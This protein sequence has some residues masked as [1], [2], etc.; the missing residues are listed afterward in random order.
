M[1]CAVQNNENL[2]NQLNR[3]NISS[4]RRQI[5]MKQSNEPF[6]GTVTNAQSEITDMDNFPYNR[7]YR[8]V[9]NSSDPVVME[10]EAGFRPIVNSCYNL[11]NCPNP[12]P[13]P[14]HC[15]ETSCS[16]VFP[17]YPNTLTRYADR[18]A[19]LLQ[20]NNQCISQYR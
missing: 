11:T 20:I 14:N 19:I 2:T 1:S 13:Y 4:V 17:C 3:Q 16:T 12:S 10:R 6:F 15:W 8:G 5:H 7:F 18:D 9:Y